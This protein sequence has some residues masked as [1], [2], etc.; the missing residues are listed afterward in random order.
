MN[1][2]TS[3]IVATSIATIIKARHQVQLLSY[4]EGGYLRQMMEVPTAQ[5]KSEQIFF[6]QPKAH[7]FKFADLNKMVSTDLLKLI[8]F[9]KQC[10]ATNKVAGI[11]K[12]IAKD[13][14]Q[15]KEKKTA[16]LPTARSC[17]SSYQQH[18]HH[19]YCDYHQCDQHDHDDC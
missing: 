2:A 9:F 16:H 6:V 15:P 8:A 3:S 10:Q 4:L 5:E 12:K 7:Q 14:K 17:V 13:K 11:L 19:K 18:C 1:Q